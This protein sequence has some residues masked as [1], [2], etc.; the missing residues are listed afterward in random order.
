MKGRRVDDSIQTSVDR[1][2]NAVRR[3]AAKDLWT[4]PPPSHESL[5]A[6]PYA[7]PE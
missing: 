5:Q 1:R 2:V 6:I 4:H 7:A 3:G